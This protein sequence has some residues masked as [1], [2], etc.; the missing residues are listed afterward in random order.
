MRTR[1]GK[2]ARLPSKLREE[3]N[4]RLLE[5]EP[6]STILSWLNELPEVKRSLAMHPRPKVHG[7]DITPIDDMNLT[8]W[9]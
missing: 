2:I 1:T 5:N 7:N 8:L 3:I 4:Q 9:R 6:A